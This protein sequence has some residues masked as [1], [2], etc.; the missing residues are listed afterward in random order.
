LRWPI[1]NFEEGPGTRKGGTGMKRV[2]YL[3]CSTLMCHGVGNFT[4]SKTCSFLY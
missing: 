2:N 3:T 1:L 4:M